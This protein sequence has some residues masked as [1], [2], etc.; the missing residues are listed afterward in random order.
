[1]QLPWL[2]EEK[3]SRSSTRWGCEASS[4]AVFFT[5]YPIRNEAIDRR[6]IALQLSGIEC[7]VAAVLVAVVTYRKANDGVALTAS[8]HSLE[9][10]R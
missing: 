5:D 9:T 3:S 1:M 6:L 4:S 7:D 8:V 2:D 10:G